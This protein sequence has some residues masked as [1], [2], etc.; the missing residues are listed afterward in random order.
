MDVN[1]GGTGGLL[2]AQRSLE[3]ELAYSSDC[4]ALN[5]LL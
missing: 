2:M 5:V 4:G 1:G 3:L